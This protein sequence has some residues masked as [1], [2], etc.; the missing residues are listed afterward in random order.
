MRWIAAALVASSLGAAQLK[1][2]TSA[3]FDRY[4]AETEHRLDAAKGQLWSDQAA[5]R[6]QRVRAGEVVVEPFRAKPLTEVDDGLIHDWVGAVYLP[7]VSVERTL[8]FVQDYDHA[9]Q[10]FKPEVV[11]S[12]LLSRDGEHFRVFMRL[13]KKKVITVVLDTE[14]DVRYERL[15]ERRW[16]SASRT[17]KIAEV[18]NPG[19]KN[20]KALPPGT[21]NGFLWR[22]NSYWRFEERDGGTVVE[23]EAIS[24]TR[25]VPMGLGWL[26][27]PIIKNLPKDSL[28]NTLRATRDALASRSK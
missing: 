9:A 21:G 7:G 10:H 20:E 28:Q 8:A 2:G 23:C 11:E 25:D 19:K 5:A 15:D 14:H 27:E 16:R 3:A 1:P 22:L 17:T 6:A 18:E 12:R 24:L 26:I 4:I 13:L